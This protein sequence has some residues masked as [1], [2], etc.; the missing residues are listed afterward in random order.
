VRFQ[1]LGPLRVIDDG[2]EDVEL[3][4]RQGALLAILLVNANQVVSTD[5]LADLLWPTGAPS[6]PRRTLRFHIS[7]LRD[8]LHPGRKGDPSD[9]AIVTSAPGYM[10]RVARDDVDAFVFEDMA[11]EAR[12]LAGS[13][14]AHA[15]ELMSSALAL[16]RGPVLAEFE[17]H[18]FARE[19]ALRFQEM[20]LSVTEDRLAALID[21]GSH[22]AVIGELEALAAEHPFRERIACLLMLALYRSGRQAEALRACG[23]LRAHLVEELGIDPSEPTRD[24]EQRILDQD[25]TLHDNTPG[26][27]SDPVLR[28]VKDFQLVQRVGEG[29][30]GI[31]YRARQLS[32]GRD[33]AIKAIRPAYASDPEFLRRFEAEAQLVAGL[34]HPHIAP[35]YDFWREP[36]SAYLAMRLL[37]GGSLRESLELGP[38]RPEAVARLVEQIAAAASAAH[39]QGVIHRDIKPANILLDEEGNGYLADFGIAKFLDASGALT[40]T[41]GVPV[42]PAYV[43]P[44]LLGGS[45]TVGPQSD[46]YSLGLV[47]FEALTGRHPYPT[48]SVQAMINRQLHDP[49]PSVEGLPAVD[50]VLARATA[51]DPADRHADVREFAHALAEVLS[52]DP[53]VRAPSIGAVE[54]DESTV[55]IEDFVG[56]ET[57]F[58]P[59]A[60]DEISVPAIYRH[61]YDSDNRIYEEIMQRNP[62]FIVGRR[63]AGKTAL[64][65][66]PLL[67]P[68]NLLVEF[69]SSDLFAQVLG[70]VQ[71][72]E[73]RGG[74]IFTSQIG[75]IW[76]GVVWTGLCLATLRSVDGAAMPHAEL[77]A[78]Q[79]FVAGYGDASTLTIDRV[80]MEHC[81]KI[82]QVAAVRGVTAIGLDVMSGGVE[83][84]DA[85]R[86]CL[87]LLERSGRRPIVLMD[88]MEDAHA[89]LDTL[90]RV[91]A[92][93]FAYIG[94]SDRDPRSEIRFRFC[95]PSELWS[96]L[97]EFAANPLKDAENHIKLF[98]HARELIKI[99]GHR[100]SLYLELC[101][102]DALERL[103]GRTG[104]DATS[105]DDARAV[106]S[107]VLPP[108][109]VNQSGITENTLAFTLRHTQ[110]LPRHFLQILNGVMRR[111][112]EL[113]EPALSVR[114][115]AVTD[116]VHRVEELL[117]T[118]I[119]TAYSAVHPA[120]REVCRRV[121]PELPVAFSD[122]QLHRTFNRA[123]IRKATGLAYFDFKEMLLE[124]GCL[125]RVLGSTDRYVEGEFDYTLPTPLYPGTDDQLCLHPLFS[126]VF[127]ARREPAET[128]ES[129]A[130]VYPYGADPDHA[131][132]W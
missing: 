29:R 74:R 120:A 101:H 114:P 32:V 26:R 95:Y 108:D 103:F 14:P 16:W 84:A 33:V 64:M 65:R 112:R 102:P 93:L 18:D 7:K 60:M 21:T 99:A 109:I 117:V 80:A 96:K 105:F 25:P 61:L 75:D 86:A 100:L 48:D 67:D 104:Y 82:G 1:I 56:E 24:L 119:F 83:L 121:I 44:E 3:S 10:I 76:E 30:F 70:C 58:G 57:P 73:Q 63:G 98:W 88:S 5:R 19:T 123:G 126:E 8:R 42:T 128:E 41:G 9:G 78:V 28:R 17:Y 50:E 77:R 51:K 11:R 85:K 20:R 68:A 36:E 52:V 55:T 89:E 13:D 79:R 12:E 66:V 38:W 4:A 47:T 125:G 116:G 62:S 46:L 54:A 49:L 94:R 43:A 72:V 132:T 2:G 110:L 90:A 97:S 6:N 22:A 87:T 31:V 118:E 129:P 111:N 131:A 37:R 91:L 71:A 113:G 15:A 124:I 35:L 45:G 34:E 53:A 107:A 40:G 59:I 122:G 23:R 81:R 106:L 92:G 27:L 69:N 130:L 115:E 127:Q 39:R